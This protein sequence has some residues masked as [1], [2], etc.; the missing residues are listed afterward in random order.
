M[1]I[2][3]VL[4][5]SILGDNAEITALSSEVQIL[6]EGDFQFRLEL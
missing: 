2:K 3:I 5:T 1:L 6:V 4:L